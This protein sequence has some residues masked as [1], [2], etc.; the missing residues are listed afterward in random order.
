MMSSTARANPLFFPPFLQVLR[1]DEPPERQWAGLS[2]RPQLDSI[3]GGVKGVDGKIG[4][5]ETGLLEQLEV[6]L[7]GRL[8]AKRTVLL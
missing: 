8:L 1:A 3:Q 5:L 7:E 2:A 4:Q 6:R